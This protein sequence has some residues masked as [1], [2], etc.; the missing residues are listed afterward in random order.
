M[1]VTDFRYYVVFVD[2]NVVVFIVMF[3]S[4]Y[5]VLFAY[6]IMCCVVLIQ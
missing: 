6:L 4:L 1:T 3:P 5:L 2:R